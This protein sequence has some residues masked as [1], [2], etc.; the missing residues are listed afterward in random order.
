M[1]SFYVEMKELGQNIL[2]AQIFR[3]AVG[4]EYG[5]VQFP[6]SVLQ[7]RGVL[8]VQVRQ[9]A[10]LQF[11]CGG[12]GRLEPGV[13]FFYEFA[14]S[15]GDCFDARVVFRFFSGRPRKREDLEGGF[16]GIAK[17]ALLFTELGSE[18]ARP[19]FMNV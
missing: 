2:I 9:C 7:P 13:A 10:L 6:V 18:S 1:R 14:G 4:G 15:D 19:D 8:V 12:V 11:C 16:W 5:D 3:P 17:A